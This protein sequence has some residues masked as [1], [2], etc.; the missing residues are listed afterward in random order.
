M[1]ENDTQEMEDFME[2]CLEGAKTEV[3]LYG[4]ASVIA[5][6]R[7]SD[8]GDF[9]KEYLQDKENGKKPM[10]TIPFNTIKSGDK[11]DW[12]FLI[13]KFVER[14]GAHFSVMVA[15]SWYSENPETDD[16]GVPLY[17]PSED[18]NRKECLVVMGVKYDDAGFVTKQLQIMQPFE[19]KGDE[20]VYLEVK[21]MGGGDGVEANSRLADVTSRQDL[22]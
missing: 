10:A 1:S 21:T 8:N 18:P 16:D 3:E 6:I 4:N 12:Y 20:I 5:F 7:P 2:G 9:S 19:R 17:M 15:E 14:F 11:D 22:M 13:G